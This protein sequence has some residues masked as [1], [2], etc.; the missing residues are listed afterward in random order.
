VG[1]PDPADGS[2]SGVRVEVHASIVQKV[3]ASPPLILFYA[4]YTTYIT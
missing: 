2:G 3:G 4:S 1:V